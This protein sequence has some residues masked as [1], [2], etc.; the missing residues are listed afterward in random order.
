MSES[1]R[2]IPGTCPHCA[3]VLSNVQGVRACPECP[4]V[5]TDR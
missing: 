1:T 4:F 2:T 5:D 3:G